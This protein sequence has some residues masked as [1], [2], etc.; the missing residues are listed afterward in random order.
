LTPQDLEGLAPLYALG[1]LDGDD[2]ARFS[3]E[4][5]GSESLRALVREYRDATA[6]LPLSL[7]PLA[8]S[9]AGKGRLLDSVATPAQRSAPVFTRVFW[10]AAALLLAV[11]LLRSLSAPPELPGMDLRG[12]R[13]APSARGRIVWR[14]RSVE[15]TLTGLPALPPGQVYQLWHVGP[16]PRPVPVALFSV[17]ADGRAQAWATLKY[18]VEKGDGFAVTREPA[19]GSPT[20][21]L[22]LFVVPAP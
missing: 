21:T 22:P 14:A 1:A 17:D 7:E 4:L 15:L 5:Q 3:E 11:A 18:A 13:P 10:A 12:D 20:C 6:A 16:A 8:P 9:P 19:G 2:L